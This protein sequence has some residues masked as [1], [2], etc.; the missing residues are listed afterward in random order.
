MPKILIA[1]S[2]PGGASAVVP[3]AKT[4]SARGC[5]VA[6]LGTTATQPILCAAGSC[7]LLADYGFDEA[8]SGSLEGV[9][10]REQPDAILMATS[11]HYGASSRHVLEHSIAVAA[12][13]R[14]PT[15]ALVDIP[16]NELARF[17]D[18]YDEHNTFHSRPADN[19]NGMF[20]FLPDL[21]ASDAV[22]YHRMLQQGFPTEK[23]VITGNPAFDDLG[24]LARRSDEERSLA[25]KVMGVNDR[26]FVIVY[27]SDIKADLVNLGWGFADKECMDSLCKGIVSSARAQDIV[28]VL[29]KHPRE[30]Q[31]NF[32][33]LCKQAASYD[34]QLR[35][36][37]YNTRRD[38]LGSDLAVSIVSTVLIEATL[39]GK[40]ALSLQ[41]NPERAA[42]DDYFLNT[43]NLIPHA[44]HA[45]EGMQLV[46]RI[47]SDPVTE[48]APYRGRRSD[49]LVDGKA[50]ERVVNEIYRM[51]KK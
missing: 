28:L 39:L 10:A 34:L 11:A 19:P 15:L 14:V 6:L 47:S 48:L 2:H 38:V 21:I 20:A 36:S 5:D 22:A 8:T 3:P 24:T 35:T 50:T 44:Y 32:D 45:E 4:L 9:I 46:A 43:L 16:M 27:A 7:K 23:L 33:E 42:K 25:R 51:L 31:S 30:L 29:R 18:L 37:A 17:S 12:R 41:P 13:N 26:Q 49:F 1:A 40:D